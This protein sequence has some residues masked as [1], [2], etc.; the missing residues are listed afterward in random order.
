[1]KTHVALLCLLAFVAPARAVPY[2]RKPAP[3]HGFQTRIDP[4][5][6]EPGQDLEVC[7]YRRLANGKTAYV[8]RFKLRMPLGAHHFALWRYGG[9]IT[10]DSKFP[11]G[12]VPSIGCVGVAPD[13]FIPQLLVPTTTPNATYRFPK[14][15]A[16]EVAADQQVFLNAHMR[17]VEPT[18]V[19][20]DI[21]FNLYTT[22]K[23][24][25]KHRAE[26][27]TFGN[28]S[29]IHVPAGGDQ[30]LVSEWT[31]PFDLTI[32]LLTTHQ[33]R[34]GTHVLIELVGD[35]GGTSM[36]VESR[37]WQHPDSAW[38]QGGLRLAKGRKLRLTCEW[39][40]TEAQEVR[41]GPKTTD[42]MCY[43]IGFFYRDERDATAAPGPGC[44]PS[45]G[46]L[47]CPGVPAVE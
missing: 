41:F 36:L 6:V 21:R 9:A 4:Y 30:T 1:M 38:P 26:G 14:G 16:L 40:N 24:T 10:D 33:H 15:V 8:S 23:A 13:E 25:V 34:L 17:N 12:P 47:L 29:D 43:G 31:V 42:E 22:R 27:L 5:T 3:G 46:G 28:S 19:V 18:A 44:I 37:D 45:A 7:E 11:S 2:L 32:V 20:P 35:D 39:H